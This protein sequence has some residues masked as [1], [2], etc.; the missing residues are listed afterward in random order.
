MIESAKLRV[1]VGAIN[2]FGQLKDTIAELA[3]SGAS[4][5][6]AVVLT[7]PGNLCERLL[8][9]SG[10]ANARTGHD[11][12]TILVRSN[13]GDPVIHPNSDDKFGADASVLADLIT[14][15]EDWIEPR[16]A[17]N[18]KRH[19][20]DGACLLFVLIASAEAE[21]SISNALLSH[22]LDLVQFHDVARPT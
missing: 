5:R 8:G 16:L 17:R 2:D 9:A 14:T 3:S 13:G 19:L 21:I 15:F 18:L 4:P 1:A 12:P 20:A 7:I 10:L 22:A 11:W 6:D